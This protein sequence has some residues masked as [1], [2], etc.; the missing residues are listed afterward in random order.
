MVH[1]EAL[2]H[3]PVLRLDH[4]VIGVARKLSPKAVARLARLSVTD[5]IRQ[6]DEVARR[7]E[8]LTRP[9]QLA[10][11]SSADELRPAPAGAVHDQYGVPHHTL[12][13]LPW[14]AVR[15]VV[16]T[17]IRERFAR[18][19][20]EVAN[21]IVALRRLWRVGGRRL[22]QQDGK[23]QGGGSHFLRLASYTSMYF[24]MGVLAITLATTSSGRSSSCLNRRHDWPMSSFFPRFLNSS[25]RYCACFESP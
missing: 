25:S 11:E 21:D 5:V 18:R 2:R 22:T 24:C 12:R 6:D 4:V 19:E 14:L 23:Q 16:D 1:T 9:K 7:V 3:E 13:I 8:Q 15:A 20:R 10:R 17:Q